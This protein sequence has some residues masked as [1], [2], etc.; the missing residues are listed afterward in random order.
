MVLTSSLPNSAI[1]PSLRWRMLAWL[2][3]VRGLPTHEPE[4]MGLKLTC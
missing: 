1:A 3:N 4:T 2:G